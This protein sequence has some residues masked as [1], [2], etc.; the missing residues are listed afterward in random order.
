MQR[1]LDILMVLIL[2]LSFITLLAGDVVETNAKYISSANS[3]TEIKVATWDFKINNQTTDIYRCTKYT[4][5][6]ARTFPALFRAQI[7]ESLQSL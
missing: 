5:R 7:R 6:R 3:K 1:K 2:M 4:S